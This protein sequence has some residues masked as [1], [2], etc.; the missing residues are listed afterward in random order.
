MF[1]SKRRPLLLDSRGFEFKRNPECSTDYGIRLWSFESI[2]IETVQMAC[3]H[4]DS[5]ERSKFPF[6]RCRW[7]HIH[8]YWLLQSPEISKLY[9][10]AHVNPSGSPRY[11]D[12]FENAVSSCAEVFKNVAG[13]E[14]IAEK[15]FRL[16][17]KVFERCCTACSRDATQFNVLTHGDMWANNI[18]YSYDACNKPSDALMVINGCTSIT[19]GMLMHQWLV[20]NI[21][22]F[23][24]ISKL[25]TGDRLYWTWPT[26]YSH[27]H[28]SMW[29]TSNGNN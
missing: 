7:V 17:E 8:I 15:L 21:I 4:R 9:E 19:Y 16:E 27:R 13:F 20:F 18:M 10:R 14:R 22:L 23:R 5:V 25:A 28:M 12:L 29:K 6:K 2:C 11:R 24:L 1:P 26:Y 3:C